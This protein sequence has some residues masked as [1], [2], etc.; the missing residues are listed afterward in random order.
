M[1]AIARFAYTSK[2]THW[3]LIGRDDW[4]GVESFGSPVV[5]DCDYKAESKRMTDSKGVEFTASQVI[6]TEYASVKPGD[7]VLI[8]QHSGQP[9]QAWEVRATKRYADTFGQ[10]SDDWEVIT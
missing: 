3:P 7:R 10:Q 5:F 9:S 8:G 6:F 4:S 1:S 2:A